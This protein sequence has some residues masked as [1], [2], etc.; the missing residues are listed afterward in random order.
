MIT[1]M[2]GVSWYYLLAAVAT[3]ITT[4]TTPSF[5][6]SLVHSSGPVIPTLSCPALPPA[7]QVTIGSKSSGQARSME[8]QKLDPIRPIASLPQHRV[9]I[10]S[11]ASLR[12]SWNLPPG[13][14]ILNLYLSFFFFLTV[15]KFCPSFYCYY[16]YYYY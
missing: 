15:P 4:T 7:L 16:Y 14:P 3:I 8:A 13:S 12:F 11:C 6:H 5:C 10:M 9:A 1:S 2:Y